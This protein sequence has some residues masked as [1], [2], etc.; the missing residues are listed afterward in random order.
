MGDDTMVGFTKL[1]VAGHTVLTKNILITIKKTKISLNITVIT[2]ETGNVELS[3][4]RESIFPG[5]F[6]NSKVS[7][8]ERSL[9]KNIEKSVK[10]LLEKNIANICDKQTAQVAN[11]LMA[12]ITSFPKENISSLTV[13][14]ILSENI[15]FT[16]KLGKHYDIES[17]LFVP[18]RESGVV[19]LFKPLF[20]SWLTNLEDYCLLK[21][22]II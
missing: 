20:E 5:I 22:P 14:V 19:I 9:E 6:Y 21:Y 15:R 18:M 13:P 12:V 11:E 8:L 4:S 2:A 17:G 3:Q 10:N 7:G 16:D 1:D